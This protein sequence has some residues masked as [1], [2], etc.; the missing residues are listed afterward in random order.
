M[1]QGFTISDI[2]FEFDHL[3]MIVYASFFFLKKKKYTHTH[4]HTH[5]YIHIPL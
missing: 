2:K 3:V 1:S 5:T 4:T